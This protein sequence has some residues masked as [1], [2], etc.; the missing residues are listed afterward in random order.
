MKPSDLRLLSDCKSQFQFHLAVG[1]GLP[2]VSCPTTG[3]QLTPAP[4][5]ILH[6]PQV[7][8]VQAPAGVTTL[9]CPRALES[10]STIQAWSLS[11]PVLGV[12]DLTLLISKARCWSRLLAL[13]DPQ[14]LSLPAGLGA[15]T[16]MET[17]CDTIIFQSV[18]LPISWYRI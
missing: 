15:S 3:P 2:S 17:L 9:F 11:P 5:E 10:F 12:P 16:P 13:P 8:L 18:G 14:L 4:Q 1:R 6:G 7:G